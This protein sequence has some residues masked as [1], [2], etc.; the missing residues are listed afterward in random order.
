MYH[1]PL[2]FQCI[3]GCNDK[4][5]DGDGKEERE[6]GIYQILYIDDKVQC[7]ESVE[8]LRVMVGWFVG[9]CRRGQ[10]RCR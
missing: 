7:G 9:V 2:A 3:Y 10:S 8:D 5:E 6:C 4:G 1:V